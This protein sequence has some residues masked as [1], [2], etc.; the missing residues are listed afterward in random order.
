MKPAGSMRR[1]GLQFPASLW[2]LSSFRPVE[3]HGARRAGSQASLEPQIPAG[4]R[5][6]T[7]GGFAGAPSDWRASLQT[8]TPATRPLP[9]SGSVGGWVVGGWDAVPQLDSVGG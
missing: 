6:A 3:S 4:E 2:P 1:L 5:A 8:P 7:R 9:A